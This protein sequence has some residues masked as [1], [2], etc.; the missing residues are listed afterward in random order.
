MHNRLTQ[1][2]IVDMILEE[3]SQIVDALIENLKTHTGTG[4]N[5][6]PFLT[7]GLKIIHEDSGLIYTVI[8]LNESEHGPVLVCIKPT[9]ERFEIPASKFK[10]YKRL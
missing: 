2:D 7:S 10:E 5:K 8:D 9:G 4:Q 1:H 6:K 3:H